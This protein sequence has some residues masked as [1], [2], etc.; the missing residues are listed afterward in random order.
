MQDMQVE[1]PATAIA[2]QHLVLRH[3]AHAPS[4]EA[5]AV[6]GRSMGAVTALLYASTQPPKRVLS[7]LVL[8][9]PFSNLTVLAREL[10]QTFTGRRLP[11]LVMRAVL[12][13]PL[14]SSPGT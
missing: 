12:S 9:S 5:T 13:S 3:L 10:V 7:A 4:V 6:W 11:K 1:S 8:D 2:V 14:K